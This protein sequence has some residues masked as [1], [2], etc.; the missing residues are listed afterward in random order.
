MF[1]K[2]FLTLSLL[3]IVVMSAMSADRYYLATNYTMKTTGGDFKEWIQ[4]EILV[5]LNPSTKRIVISSQREQ[6]IDYVGFKEVTDSDATVLVSSATDSDY[7]PIRVSFILVNDGGILLMI[8]YNDY[9]Y[10]YLLKDI[11]DQY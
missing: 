2:V 9:Q 8:E 11:T 5:A 6:I 1:K 7:K 4:T 3:M 10:M